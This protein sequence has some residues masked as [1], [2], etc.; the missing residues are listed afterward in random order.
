MTNLF[1]KPL[2]WPIG[3]GGE[4]EESARGV[5]DVQFILAMKHFS[6]SSLLHTKV[7]VWEWDFNLLFESTV[8]LFQWE[9]STRCPKHEWDQLSDY[10]GEKRLDV[11]NKPMYSAHQHKAFAPYQ[12]HDI[13]KVIR[14]LSQNRKSLPVVRICSRN[15]HQQGFLP[16]SKNTTSPQSLLCG[17]SAGVPPPL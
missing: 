14:K 10:S 2:K 8:W 17:P 12:L 9:V 15:T 6:P 4:E 16:Q 1:L 5:T 13:T 11:L 7:C 3:L